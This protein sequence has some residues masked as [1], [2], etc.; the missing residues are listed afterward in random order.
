[1]LILTLFLLLT[2]VGASA[3][4][5]ADWEEVW[6]SFY[7]ADDEGDEER[8]D[9]YELL[10]QLAENPIDLNNTTREELE[11]LPFLSA[12]QVMDII[13][14][15]DRYGSMRSLGELRMIAS[16]DYQQLAL[17]PY[18]VFTGEVPIEEKPFPSFD[19]M[20]NQGRHK[21]MASGRIPF[22][23]RKGDQ[24]GY[25]G[26]KYRHWLKYDYTCRNHIR[27]GFIGTQDAGEPFFANRNSWG[28]DAYSYYFL[29][30]KWGRLERLVVGKYKAT[31]ALGL[32]MGQS[33][34]L[35]KVTLLQNLGR[36]TAQLRVHGSRSESDYFQGAGATVRLAKPLTATAFVS[37]R[38]IDATLN[39]DGTA[40]TL[41]TNGYH[42]TPLE[43]QKKHNTHLTAAGS[44]LNYHRG[45][46]Q[47]GAQAIYTHLD[48]SLQPN[49]Q[50]LFRRY[51]AHGSNF[52]NT[53]LSYAYTHAHFTLSGETAL[54]GDGHIAT[55]NTASLSPAQNL[56]LVALQR[57]YSY[58]Y[59][60]LH[61]HSYG[62]QPQN[63]SGLYL[64][65]RWNPLARCTVQ[66]YADYAYAPWARYLISQSSH[67][68]DL[69]LQV[70]KQWQDWTV[71]GRYRSMLRQRD[72]SDKTALV[73]NDSHR[74]RLS[75]TWQPNDTWSAKTQ[76]DLSHTYYQTTEKGFM[77]SEH[78]CYNQE[79]LR[80]WLTAGYFHTDSYT[81]RLYVYEHQLTGNFNFSSYY[82][83]GL[84]LAF[85]AQAAIGSHLRICAKLG[86]THY[87]DRHTIGT[88]LQQVHA[89]HLTDLDLQ[90]QYR[91]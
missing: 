77:L 57:F 63:E 16:L 35:G 47:L 40:A 8:D 39:D 6:Q 88:G 87:F 85:S 19:D 20:L 67:S 10:W 91:L 27:L 83:E 80:L 58:R 45:A 46:L 4:E 5:H 62:H 90:L 29:L 13:E 2:A 28:Y 11:Q 30:Q 32:V 12:Q 26:Y 24:N 49:R 74:L 31:A 50:T 73:A 38:P 60:T 52:L 81:S 33:F 23:E 18:F 21:L 75:A 55:I 89:R 7:M 41:I 51:Y 43:M 37:Y 22:Y 86:H 70:N 68:W 17:L 34:S 79:N 44:M 64:G 53:S 84:R 72:D 82:G 3:Q 42:R 25:L 66:A 9:D 78:L 1:M 54:D 76:A 61:G 36:Q 14:Y 59:T 69:F 48:R 65:L 71:E 15:L 56:T